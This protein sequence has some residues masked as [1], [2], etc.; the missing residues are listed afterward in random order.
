M[1]QNLADL[2]KEFELQWQT[3]EDI[4]GDRSREG[5]NLRKVM[6]EIVAGNPA[7]FGKSE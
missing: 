4:L 2:L 3:G 1:E 5:E 6:E 7:T